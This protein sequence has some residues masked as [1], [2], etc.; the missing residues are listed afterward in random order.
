MSPKHEV[1]AR[2]GRRDPRGTTRASTA[3]PSQS[4]C[5]RHHAPA[6]GR[7]SRPSARDR[8]CASG[9]A[10]RRSR[11]CARAPRGRRARP[12]APRPVARP[13]SPRD[14]PAARSRN[15]ARRGR[16]CPSA[17]ERGQSWETPDR[18]PAPDAPL[19]RRRDWWRSRRRRTP[20]PRAAPVGEHAAR[21]P[22]RSACSA[23]ASHGRHDRVGHEPR[24]ARSPPAGS[25]SSRPSSARSAA[26]RGADPSRRVAPG[27]ANRSV[28]GDHRGGG[29]QRCPETAHRRSRSTS[30][31]ASRAPRSSRR[32]PG[33][34]R[35][36]RARTRRSTTATS[37]PHSG[38]P[39]TNVLVPSIGSISQR[40]RASGA[41]TPSSSPTMPS[42]GKRAPIHSRARVL[43]L[44]VGDRDRRAVRLELD[45]EAAP[46]S[47]QRDGATRGAPASRDDLDQARQSAPVMSC[48]DRVRRRDP[49]RQSRPGERRLESP[50]PWSRR[51]GASRRAALRPRR[52][53][54][55]PRSR[56]PRR[57]PPPEAI[58]GTGHRAREPRAS[59]RDRSPLAPPSRSMLVSRIS[60]A[61]RRT[62][63]APTPPPRGPVGGAA[64]RVHERSPSP[65]RRASMLATTHW[66]PKRAAA[67][68]QDLGALDRRRVEAHL[69]GARAQLPGHRRRRSGCRRRS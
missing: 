65:S 45:R 19:P 61:P 62:H 35:L 8:A 5:E 64:V 54:A 63:S 21:L 1:D 20:V 9:S 67:L 26:R 32:A 42:P 12:S 58:T 69:V 40:R 36:R 34:T 38:T 28:G 23:A 52:R 51:R 66:L 41:V 48:S 43:G 56:G 18:P 16:A 53:R 68:G 55:A 47:A 11:A 13:A 60:P 30:S 24:R 2:C 25:R 33:S 10:S 6:C 59:A 22:R 17:M 15:R 14:E 50:R 49:H 4:A 46:R 57:P 39:R 29:D 31:A 27:W 44:A 7:W 37:E 3:S